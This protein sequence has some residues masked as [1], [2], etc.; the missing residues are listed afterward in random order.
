[1]RATNRL[2]ASVKAMSWQLTI[3]SNGLWSGVIRP[4]QLQRYALQRAHNFG[5]TDQGE[6]RSSP[7]DR[8]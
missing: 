5:S 8:K 3:A 6:M 1:M 7:E 4:A 2:A